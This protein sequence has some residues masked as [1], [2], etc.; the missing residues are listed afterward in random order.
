KTKNPY[1][2]KRKTA[3]ST[4]T[5]ENTKG[6]TV[7]GHY[8][9]FIA[10]TLDILDQHE[11]RKDNYIVMDN[12]PIHKNADI[13]KYIEQR[14]YGWPIP[15]DISQLTTYPFSIERQVLS[16]IEASRKNAL[17]EK[18]TLRA[19]RA[20]YEQEKINQ[21][22]LA[23]RRIAPGFLDT[24]TR[25]LKPEQ[26]YNPTPEATVEE[27][28]ELNQA[29]SE[30]SHEKFDYLRFEQ[31]LAPADPWDAPENDFVALRSVL[32]SSPKANYST[33]TSRTSPV[34]YTSYQQQQQPRPYPPKNEG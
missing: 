28:Q 29:S 30:S 23:A 18:E 22:K 34:T 1:S 17:E 12:A 10:S 31:G 19:K 8:F 3:G 5:V 20:Q 13:R 4:Q 6:G 24:D 7:N 26:K 16:Y 27:P 33:P 2:K 25:I 9:N 15:D 21:Q 11:Q 32:G 14:S